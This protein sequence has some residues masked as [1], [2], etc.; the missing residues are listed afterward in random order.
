MNAPPPPRLLRLEEVSVNR[1]LD[2]RVLTCLDCRTKQL[3]SYCYKLIGNSQY[4]MDVVLPEELE[5]DERRMSAWIHFADGNRRDGVGDQ[6][7]IEGVRTE[8]HQKNELCLFDHGKTVVLPIGKTRDPETN[9]YTVVLDPVSQTGKANV[10]FYSGN[11]LN[12][13]N[14]AAEFSHAI[15]CEQLFDL[16]ARKFLK[17]GSIGYT[18]VRAKELPPDRERGIP[19]GLYLA[20]VNLLEVSVVGLPASPDTVMKSKCFGCQDN[21]LEWKDNIRSCIGRNCCGKPLSPVLVK[22]LQPYLEK[23]LVWSN[24]ADWKGNVYTKG[25]MGTGGEVAGLPVN[26]LKPK[27]A[28]ALL[29]KGE[30]NGKPINPSEQG[31]FSEACNRQKTLRKGKAMPNDKDVGTIGKKS[32]MERREKY[33]RAKAFRRRLRKSAAGASSMWIASKDLDLLRNA[34]GEKGVKLQWLG[35]SDGREKVKLLGDDENIDALALKYGKRYATRVKGKSRMKVK[36][37]GLNFMQVMYNEDDHRWYVFDGFKQIAGPYNTR[38][39]ATNILNSIKESEGAFDPD[40]EAYS[41]E[42]PMERPYK[43]AGIKMKIKTKAIDPMMEEDMGDDTLDIEVMGDEPDLDVDIEEDLD[44]G[45]MDIEEKDMGS[46]MEKYGAQVLRR[47]HQH[48]IILMEEYDEMMN[49]LEEETVK[50][51]LQAILEHQ[52]EVLEATEDLFTSLYAEN[53][54]L[55]DAMG[56]VGEKDMDAEAIED[57]DIPGDSDVDD[58]PPEE[59]A[60]EGMMTKGMKNKRTKGAM[61]AAAGAG[62]GAVAG[63]PVGAVIGGALGA[64]A[65]KGVKKKGIPAAVG[66]IASNPRVQAA[67]RGAVRGAVAG[68]LT[69]K[70]MN[71]KKKGCSCHATKDLTRDELGDITDELEN[72]KDDL[73]EDFENVESKGWGYKSMLGDRHGRLKESH[74]FLK[75]LGCPDSKF[76]DEERLKSYHYHKTMDDVDSF[77]TKAWHKDINGTAGVP[78]GNL[79]ETNVPPPK[80]KPGVGAQK[81]INSGPG[82]PPKPMPGKAMPGSDEWKDEEMRE[83]EHLD[84]TMDPMADMEVQ[85]KCAYPHQ[86]IVK[87][88]SSLFKALSMERAFGEPH[89]TKALMCAKDMEPMVNDIMEEEMEAEEMMDADNGMAKGAE[90]GT[91][92]EPGDMDTKSIKA[93]RNGFIVQGYDIQKLNNRIEALVDRLG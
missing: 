43:G 37:K 42:N 5:I 89:R 78:H 33:R 73:N 39:E 29:H 60:V 13:T 54:P 46:D 11:G 2:A 32:M 72:V 62:L 27:E 76:D 28:C 80:W 15:F 92:F 48:H 19:A 66:A 9:E 90:E 81:T 85:T 23:S 59:E 7:A 4:G 47:I 44:T 40:W 52:E 41:K 25:L 55:A 21:Y 14:R 53:E 83:P 24:G 3:P 49:M 57:A 84:N 35:S 30:V 61:G 18:I 86:Q 45:D 70:G 67:G 71:T 20:S 22:S 56:S 34:A 6:L 50:K 87:G 51:H 69:G 82:Q 68:A 38:T 12:N 17:G 74:E 91:P 64:S 1:A 65:S 77:L 8:R 36:T 75:G 58:L 31:L 16:L 79:S 93:M 10:F 63:G 88:A 26:S